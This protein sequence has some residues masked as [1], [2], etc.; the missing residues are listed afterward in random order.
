MADAPKKWWRL[1]ASGPLALT[2]YFLFLGLPILVYTIIGEHTLGV[3]VVVHYG[4]ATAYCITAVMMLAETAKA[5]PRRRAPIAALEVRAQ[6]PLISVIVS[7]YLPNEQDLIVETIMHLATEMNVPSYNLQLILAY[8]SPD[9]LPVEDALGSLNRITA[10]F[11]PLRVTGSRSKAENIVAALQLCEG[12]MT[13][14]LDADHHPLPDAFERAYRWLMR[15]YDV[16]QGRCV[17]RNQQENTQ[18][19]YLSVEFEQMYAVAHSGRSLATDNA[20]FA[21]TN[22]Y[23]R[24]SALKE[25]GMD[26]RMLT[27]DIDSSIRG[28]LAGYRFVHDRSIVSSELATSTWQAWWHQRVRWAQGW[29]QVT[30]AHQGA[31]WRS[32]RLSLKTKLYWTYLLSWRE[33]FPFLSLQVFALLAAS[34]LLGRPVPWF[35]NAYFV[36]TAVLTLVSGPI[37]AI[38]TYNVALWRTKRDLGRWFV[39]YALTSLIYTTAK[40][41]VA[42]VAMVRQ[43]LGEQGW[44]V[45]RRSTNAPI[46]SVVPGTP[47]TTRSDLA[48]L[49]R[50]RIGPKRETL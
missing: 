7:A 3:L 38:C 16:V 31:I 33:V 18:T 12:E 14:L 28:M 21:G 36:G 44:V 30:L 32:P 29:L 17:V 6:V 27:E 11:T 26:T 50:T 2:A 46:A 9:D 43:A 1:H 22:G 5:L 13:V 10:N 4:V 19:R 23:W 40:N 34:V 24:T 49:E 41:T 45:T 8:N 39:V 35:G 25:I 47:A 42:M 37:A 15:G 20:I 48:P